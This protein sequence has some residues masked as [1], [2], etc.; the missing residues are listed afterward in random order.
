MDYLLA[1]ALHLLVGCYFLSEL[2]V[3]LADLCL[4][5]AQDSLAG[6]LLLQTQTCVLVE[7]S[8]ELL[9]AQGK[10]YD[11]PQRGLPFL[12]LLPPLA[13]FTARN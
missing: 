1:E 7:L 4:Y 9:E 6:D 5:L 8:Y 3:D 12:P 2:A 13:L 10:F 11:F